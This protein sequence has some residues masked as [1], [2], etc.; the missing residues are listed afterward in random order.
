M[1]TITLYNAR[2]VVKIHSVLRLK[3]HVQNGFPRRVQHGE[4]IVSL[5]ISVHANRH[6]S[7]STDSFQF[8]SL[9][10]IKDR[11]SMQ[12]S[13]DPSPFFCET[14]SIESKRVIEKI[15]PFSLLSSFLFFLSFPSFWKFFFP[16]RSISRVKEEQ[17]TATRTSFPA[18]AAS[19]Y[20]LLATK[21]S[22]GILAENNLLWRP[23][24]LLPSGTCLA[25]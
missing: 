15:F 13:I 24:T 19:V 22:R 18:T 3:L 25:K 9:S 20:S 17:Q 21:N 7:N 6:E 14:L 2:R 12:Y 1:N 16:D 10:A 5:R 23:Q 8:S 4:A 11:D